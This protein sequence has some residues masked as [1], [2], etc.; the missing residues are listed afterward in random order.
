MASSDLLAILG[1]A[2]AA[3]VLHKGSEAAVRAEFATA[4]KDDAFLSAAR[5]ELGR[6]EALERKVGVND[7]E[8][9]DYAGS[10]M[11]SFLRS[12]LAPSA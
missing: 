5:A 9:R 8:R 1:R 7:L 6:L 4:A 3:R 11:L 10:V 12:A 2:Y